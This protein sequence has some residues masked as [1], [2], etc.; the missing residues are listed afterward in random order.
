MV[1]VPR[2]PTSVRRIARKKPTIN[3]NTSQIIERYNSGEREF[4]NIDLSNADLREVNLSDANLRGAN[5]SNAILIKANLKRADLTGANLKRASLH[6]AKLQGTCLHKTNL[7]LSDLIQADLSGA[8]LSSSMM[9]AADL[10]NAKLCGADLSDADLS[11]ADLSETDLTAVCYNDKTHFDRNFNPDKIAAPQKLKITVAQIVEK[12]NYLSQYSN[13]YLGS[14]MTIKYWQSSR[15]DFDWLKKI[16]FDSSAKINFAGVMSEPITSLQ[17]Q[18]TQK[19][20]NT[21]IKSC[22]QIIQDFPALIK[23]KFG[24]DYNVILFSNSSN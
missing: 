4:E 17:L 12:L 10:T 9:D 7:F 14:K 5:L 11:G 13:S 1:F 19:W 24:Q 3:P 21:F 20:V 15:P 16:Q 22:S 23:Q 18:W 2:D 6:K 8:D